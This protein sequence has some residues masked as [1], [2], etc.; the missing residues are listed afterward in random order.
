MAVRWRV[1]ILLFLVRMTMAFQFQLVGALSPAFQEAF[2]VGIADI[3]ILI[4]LYL[5]PGLFLA[6][7]GGA[8]GRQFGDKQVVLFGLALMTAGGALMAVSEIWT[9]QL[10]G[11]LIAGVGGVLLNVLMTKMVADWFADKE[12]SF[13]LAVFVNSW[14][15]G[16]AVALIVLPLVADVGGLIAALVL[17]VS[18]TA[19]GLVGLGLFYRPP[20]GANTGMPTANDGVRGAVLGA[21]LAAGAIW[22]LYNA[23]LG[24]VFSFGPQLFVA[25]G[26][27]LAEAGSTTSIV[28]WLLAI[29]GSF[30]GFLTDWTGRRNLILVVG[31]LGFALFVLI[32]SWTEQVMLNV[33]VMGMFSGISIGAMISL[34]SLVLIPAARAV[35][36]GIFFTVFYF[37]STFGPMIAGWLADLTG[38]ISATYQ[39]AAALLVASVLVLPIYQRLAARA[40]TL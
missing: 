26:M 23:A 7:P 32:G 30:A 4:G 11:R 15:A 3:G 1:L 5:S 9:G 21:V 18:L 2:S 25:K 22:G 28:L 10:A 8:L 13:S 31:N 40:G 33:I 36:M 6:A 24:I 20:R 34:P 14:P 17:V 19:A 27:A 39:L 37:C 12:I 38:D 16:I 29:I 35:G